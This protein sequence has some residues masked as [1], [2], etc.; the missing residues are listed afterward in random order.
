METT[1]LNR[2]WSK[3]DKSIV[4]GCWI[5][6]AYKNPA[7]YGQVRVK[8]IAYLAHRFSY[9]LAFGPIPPTINVLH[10]C[11]NPPCVN[12][13]HLFL[14]TLTDNNQDMCRKGRHG[15]NVG[16]SGHLKKPRKG[17]KLTY[18]QVCEIRQ[19]AKAGI[20][21]DKLAED[22]KVGASLVSMIVNNKRWQH[23]Q[24]ES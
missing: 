16:E 12:P 3:V 21:Y 5:W 6:K 4:S 15:K 13:D 8:T 23:S 24:P 20:R 1:I 11:D 19:R 2:F 7:G 9:E 17:N 14:G 10:K 18:S 22:Y